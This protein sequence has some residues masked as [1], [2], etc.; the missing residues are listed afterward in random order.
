MSTKKRYGIGVCA[1]VVAL[2]LA[3]AGPWRQAVW[4]ELGLSNVIHVE[5]FNPEGVELLIY[6][7]DGDIPDR[8]EVGVASIVEPEPLRGDSLDIDDID[9]VVTALGGELVPESAEIVD[10]L[11][12]VE[13]TLVNQFGD[14]MEYLA[15]VDLTELEFETVT[16][17][18][19][20]AVIA[21][22][23]IRTVAIVDGYY[24]GSRDVSDIVEGD[25]I[26]VAVE[27][28]DAAEI[29]QDGNGFPNA[30]ALLM[31]GGYILYGNNGV[32]TIV[33]DLD[34]LSRGVTEVTVDHY[35]ESQFGPVLVS[36]ESPTLDAL[37]LADDSF[38]A[39]NVARLVITISEDASDLIDTPSGF[40]PVAEFDLVDSSD[41]PLPAPQNLFVRAVIAVTSAVRG[42]AIPDW[43]FVGDLP[44]GLELIGELSGPGVAELL[45]D[46]VDVDAYSY[47]VTMAQD[48]DDITAESD[49]S[50]E[51][52]EAD[53]V[54]VTN[55]NTEDDEDDS[56]D[57]VQADD[58][59]D[60]IRATF[61]L[62]SAIFGSNATP[63]V[64]GGGGGGG[65]SGCFI[66]TAA[67]GTPLAKEIQSLR[68]VRDAYMLETALGAA[69]ADAYY[70]V[71]PPIARMIAEYPAI[72]T[73]VRAA[74]IPVV[75]ISGWIITSPGAVGAGA[76]AMLL[77]MLAGLWRKRRA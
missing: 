63:R 73:V 12:E 30:T 27:I 55:Q 47:S 26:N 25:A 8:L 52:A 50:S 53:E 58:G 22:D 66:A 40:N 23:V 64:G 15:V 71:S 75:T 33:V 6:T 37:Q 46:G 31:S 39:F 65:G 36:I 10:E 17:G 72:K 48:D 38:D 24:T 2:A 43:T 18:V 62:G 59:D 16:R 7:P 42:A 70:R 49:D 74:L 76:A 57:A 29:D 69:F 51:W 5:I 41:D 68:D 35:Y 28:R 21:E 77:L 20:P 56:R 13:A 34:S 19:L 32:I 45:E 9:S 61:S 60:T 1:G 44:G 11:F 4:A 54:Q 3:L 67:Y 14:D